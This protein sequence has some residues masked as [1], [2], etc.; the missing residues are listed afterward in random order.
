[1]TRPEVWNGRNNM[2]AVWRVCMMM[3]LPMATAILR[4][5]DGR[6]TSNSM[7]DKLTVYEYDYR[8]RRK[9]AYS[10]T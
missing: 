1:M 8:D 6:W 3:A 2:K 10:K 4:R 7:H 9:A 5:K